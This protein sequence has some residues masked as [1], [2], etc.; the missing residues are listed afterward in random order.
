MLLLRLSAV[1][2]RPSSVVQFGFETGMRQMVRG[3]ASTEWE[4]TAKG[5]TSMIRCNGAAQHSGDEARGASQRE[6]S[7]AIW[8]ARKGAT[9]QDLERPGVG[10]GE[11][12]W[13]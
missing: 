6:K 13:T 2:G 9:Q 10:A 12:V 1:R 4:A 5:F 8:P 7:R 11:D 3:G